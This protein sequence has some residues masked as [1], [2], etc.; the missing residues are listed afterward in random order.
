M[1]KQPKDWFYTSFDMFL[2]TV[3]EFMDFSSARASWSWITGLNELTTRR[4]LDINDGHY[5]T[6]QTFIVELGFL[7]VHSDEDHQRQVNIYNAISDFCWLHNMAGICMACL[8]AWAL[9]L[10]YCMVCFFRKAVLKSDIAVALN[11]S[12]IGGTQM[13]HLASCQEICR[14]PNLNAIKFKLSLNP[15]CTISN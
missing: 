4:N 13:S 6:K 10:D 15:T 2:W 3:M 1:L 8:G 12:G 7:G 11:L 14:A 5:R 9:Y